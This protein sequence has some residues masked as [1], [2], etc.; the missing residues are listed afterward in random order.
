MVKLVPIA[1]W[2][3]LDTSLCDWLPGGIE[4]SALRYVALSDG[5]CCGIVLAKTAKG[6]YVM[7]I[8]EVKSE[9][10]VYMGNDDFCFDEVL[11]VNSFNSMDFVGYAAVKKNGKWGVVKLLE[12]GEFDNR[13][14]MLLPCTYEFAEEALSYIDEQP[15][16][17]LINEL[18]SVPTDPFSQPEEIWDG[19]H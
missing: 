13:I 10:K 12:D 9:G 3:V 11:C 1:N 4:A 14:Q 16:H 18:G 2:L 7:H 5:W 8:R 17:C 19:R 6:I 15:Y